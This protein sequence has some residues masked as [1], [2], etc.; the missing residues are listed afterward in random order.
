MLQRV[1]GSIVLFLFVF[2]LSGW[3]LMP[4]LPPVPDRPITVFEAE[5]WIDNWAGG[6]LGV[7]AVLLNLRGM[8]P[9]KAGE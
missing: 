4:H 1:V 6:L 5:Y 9:A 7:V 8:K 3:F 2:F